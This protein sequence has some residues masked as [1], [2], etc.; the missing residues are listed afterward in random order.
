MRAILVALALIPT[1]GWAATPS[2][3]RAIDAKILAIQ[4]NGK[5]LFEGD[6]LDRYQLRVRLSRI[7]GREG[8]TNILVVGSPQVKHGGDEWVLKEL[9][10]ARCWV[11]IGV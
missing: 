3:E 5:V 6:Q 4:P 1:L 7:C 9:R 10:A 2:I 8:Q 11:S